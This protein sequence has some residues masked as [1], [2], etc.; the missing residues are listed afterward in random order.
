MHAAKVLLLCLIGLIG[1]DFGLASV[2]HVK[3]GGS[4]PGSEC[5]ATLKQPN[6]KNAAASFNWQFW[7]QKTNPWQAQ[8]PV[9]ATEKRQVTLFVNNDKRC[10]AK[11]WVDLKTCTMQSNPR[12]PKSATFEIEKHFSQPSPILPEGQSSEGTVQWQ[13]CPPGMTVHVDF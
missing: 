1:L 6:G 2:A 5:T 11:F 3:R 4:F 9:G 13:N 7:K 10:S 12:L 8:F